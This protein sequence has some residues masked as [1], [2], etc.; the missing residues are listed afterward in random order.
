MKRKLSLHWMMHCIS[1]CYAYLLETCTLYVDYATLWNIN[2]QK[3]H[4]WPMPE[5]IATFYH[6]YI[7]F[8][9]ESLHTSLQSNLSNS[10]NKDDWFIVTVGILILC[11]VQYKC[12]FMD[13]IH[14]YVYLFVLY[15]FCLTVNISKCE[16]V[17]LFLSNKIFIIKSL[18][19][20]YI[21]CY[22]YPKKLE[23]Y[24]V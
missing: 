3:R 23:T 13:L 21:I 14:W 7:I 19:K 18:E 11:E 1:C 5:V 2:K 20:M 16:N 10:I 15:V 12:T 6:T 24:N 4:L 22:I 9:Q 8:W 17:I